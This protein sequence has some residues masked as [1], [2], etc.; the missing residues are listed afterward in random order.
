MSFW[1]KKERLWSLLRKWS[2]FLLDVSVIHLHFVEHVQFPAYRIISTA[3]AASPQ[4]TDKQEH[5]I[6]SSFHAIFFFW[7]ARKTP[8]AQSERDVGKVASGSTNFNPASVGI[9]P[10]QE[11]DVVKRNTH[12][13]RGASCDTK[14]QTSLVGP[15]VYFCVQAFVGSNY[16]FAPLFLLIFS[17]I[18]IF[19][20]EH[21]AKFFSSCRSKRLH[22]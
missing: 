4:G 17:R 9:H 16:C 18:I 5:Q 15:L 19:P 21:Y 12:A 8:W 1:E 13:N 11:L 3:E 7:A 6:L 14:Q 20:A 2:N 10:R 22:V